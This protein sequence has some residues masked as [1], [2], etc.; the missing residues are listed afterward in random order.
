[1]KIQLTKSKSSRDR[2]YLMNGQQ[3]N[4]GEPLNHANHKFRVVNGI[5]RGRGYQGY[6]SL[7]HFLTLEYVPQSAK[8]KVIEICKK[9]NLIYS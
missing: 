3:G 5:D 2:Y 4:A 1:M 7:S 6:S 8:N 9:E